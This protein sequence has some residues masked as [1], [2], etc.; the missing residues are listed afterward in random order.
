MQ[1]RAALTSNITCS[2]TDSPCGYAARST[3]FL[4]AVTIAPP[5]GHRHGHSE[6]ARR[7]LFAMNISGQVH[8]E[9]I[10]QEHNVRLQT[11][12]NK[13]GPPLSNN[14]DWRA[15]ERVITRDAVTNFLIEY[16]GCSDPT[17]SCN[18]AAVGSID[19]E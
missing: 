5:T 7:Y 17:T 13:S 14:G 6:L 10:H 1:L 3:A 8:V 18:A 16:V 19:S 4:A 12:W 11:A 15:L 9:L 2:E